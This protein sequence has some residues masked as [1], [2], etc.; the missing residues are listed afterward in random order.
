MTQI[1]SSS[2]IA[3]ENTPSQMSRFQI[4]REA[5]AKGPGIVSGRRI[6]GSEFIGSGFCVGT[7]SGSPSPRDHR[8]HHVR[9]I[10]FTVED[11]L[12]RDDGLRLET[13]VVRTRV[14]V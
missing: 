7:F 5:R 2:P 9:W 6:C 3:T 12:F 4:E 14:E 13:D 11:P 10:L 8:Q 1:A